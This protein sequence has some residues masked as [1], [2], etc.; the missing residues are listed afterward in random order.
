MPVCMY[1]HMC[2]YMCVCV[3]LCVYVNV[4]VNVSAGA[5]E[6]EMRSSDNLEQCFSSCGS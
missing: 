5:K 6:I 3:C 4:C 2:A 1:M